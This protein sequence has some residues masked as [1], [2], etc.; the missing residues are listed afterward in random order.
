MADAILLSSSKVSVQLAYY[1]NLGK[2][3]T[4]SINLCYILNDRSFA[5]EP[6]FANHDRGISLHSMVHG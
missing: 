3:A 6:H 1:D 2:N 4:S 5:F